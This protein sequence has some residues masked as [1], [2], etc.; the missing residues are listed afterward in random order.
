MLNW[1]AADWP[2]AAKQA[3]V[4]GWIKYDR[5]PPDWI[6]K[7]GDVANQVP[8]NGTG[9]R[10]PECRA[11]AIKFALDR[12]DKA[13]SPFRVAV[14]ERHG[15]ESPDLGGLRVELVPQPVHI[16]HRFD[17]ENHLAVHIFELD[18]AGEQA[19]TNYELHFTRREST[20]KGALQL[21]EPIMR[22][23]TDSSDVIRTAK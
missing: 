11:S 8:A 15:D 1:L 10:S 12:G 21:A 23:V 4:V 13:G 18:E 22:D 14:I 20:Q 5:T 9:M 16:V 6:V 3:E 7:I 19:V 17:A 2:A